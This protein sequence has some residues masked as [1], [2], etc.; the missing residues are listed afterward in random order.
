M[1]YMLHNRQGEIIGE[2]EVHHETHD[3]ISG[4]DGNIPPERWSI[5][6]IR[7]VRRGPRD[8]EPMTEPRMQVTVQVQRRYRNGRNTY[9][10][11]LVVSD[12]DVEMVR[13][14]KGVWT[15]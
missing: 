15:A 9:R 13:A 4:S 6:E 2:V 14:S 3:I 10:P 11:R 1:R 7:T 12:K 5:V 8:D